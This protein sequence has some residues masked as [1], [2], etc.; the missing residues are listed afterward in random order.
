[1]PYIDFGGGSKQTPV[2]ET[3]NYHFCDKC[4]HKY[5]INKDLFYCTITGQI[6][7]YDYKSYFDCLFK[8]EVTKLRKLVIAIFIIKNDG[9]FT[10]TGYTSIFLSDTTKNDNDVIKMFYEKAVPDIH[11]KQ[12][13]LKDKVIV[14]I[15]IGEAIENNFFR[16]LGDILPN[17]ILSDIIKNLNDNIDNLN[18]LTNE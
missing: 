15:I 3:N 11:N 12:P 6:R 13:K 10:W 18:A 5:I 7:F 9:S 8:S 1:M 14:P 2:K 4:I 17:Y 16:P